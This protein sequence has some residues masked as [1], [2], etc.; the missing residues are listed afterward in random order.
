MFSK[1]DTAQNGAFP[2]GRQL[3]GEDTFAMG[4]DVDAY[5]VWA[6]YT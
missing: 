4:S 2:P 5:K 6:D 1:K 3:R